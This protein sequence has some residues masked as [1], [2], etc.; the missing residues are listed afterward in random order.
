MGLRK[1]ARK[2]GLALRYRSSAS[3]KGPGLILGSVSG[4]LD[5]SETTLDAVRSDANLSFTKQASL[6][7]LGFAEWGAAVVSEFEL[8]GLVDDAIRYNTNYN[9]N[10]VTND[11]VNCVTFT[12]FAIAAAKR[13]AASAQ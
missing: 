3:T 8:L 11:A 5:I 13:I 4:Y 6:S 10:T 2:P 7:E 9:F 12:G 1:S